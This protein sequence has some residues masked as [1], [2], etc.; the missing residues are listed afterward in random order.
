MNNAV[1]WDI[2]TQFVPHRKHIVSTTEGSLLM[3]F[4]IWSFHGGDYE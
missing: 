4:N 1:F 3:A 2:G